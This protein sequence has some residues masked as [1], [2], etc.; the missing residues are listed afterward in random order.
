MSDERAIAAA[1]KNADIYEAVFASHGLRFRRTAFAFIGE[2]RPPP[3]HSNLTV[4]APDRRDEVLAAL[5]DLARAFG[6]VGIKDSFAESDLRAEGF[7][8]LFAASWLWREPLPAASAWRVAD[9]PDALLAWEATW[10]RDSPTLERM[11]PD[12]LLSGGDLTFLCRRNDGRITAGCLANRSG[13]VVGVSNL[14]AADEPERL[15]AEATAAV[16]AFHPGLPI[17]G[18]ARGATLQ[19]ARAEGHVETGPL[20]V[21]VARAAPLQRGGAA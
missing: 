3:Y 10:K 21:L 16:A 2:D 9:T 12:A 18:Y 7:E 13:D 8:P 5:R 19:A 14:F 11:F 20:R 4:L 17:V 6:D 1:R 15:F